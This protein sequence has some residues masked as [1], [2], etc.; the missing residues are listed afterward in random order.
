MQFYGV[1]VAC[2]MEEI[3]A[4]AVR[5]Q[6]TLSMLPTSNVYNQVLH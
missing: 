3:Y 1:G 4:R 5:S 2:L 6:G